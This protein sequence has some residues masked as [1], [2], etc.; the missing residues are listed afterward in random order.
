MT[1]KRHFEINWPLVIEKV[2]SKFLQKCFGQKGNR[3]NIV[4]GWSLMYQIIYV[5]WSQISTKNI[6]PGCHKI[7]YEV[8]K[9]PRSKYLSNYSMESILWL[10]FEPSNLCMSLGCFCQEGGG[11]RRRR[12]LLAYVSSATKAYQWHRTYVITKNPCTKG[13][14]SVRS[15][16]WI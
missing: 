2:C 4:Y 8:S 12:T 9:L 3:G 11:K 15:S 7:P 13:P 16:V 1:P 14:N 10:V 6:C 5:R